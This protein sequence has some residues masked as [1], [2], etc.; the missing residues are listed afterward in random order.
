MSFLHPSV[1]VSDGKRGVNEGNVVGLRSL[2]RARCKR[3]RHCTRDQRNEFPPP[4]GLPKAEHL[5]TLPRQRAGVALCITTN[6]SARLP[7]WVKTG[8]AQCEHM[9]SALPPKSGHCATDSTCPFRA[10][11]GSQAAVI[12][13][14]ID[15]VSRTSQKVCAIADSVPAC[16]ASVN[17][18]L[19]SVIK[20]TL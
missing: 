7:L 13:P 4:H 3:P 14:S 10:N 11:T 1:H 8:K 5:C 12:R 15:C 17:V 6:S 9:F 18:A 19:A 16:S 2:L 20:N